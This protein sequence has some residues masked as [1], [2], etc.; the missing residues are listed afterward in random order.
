M[1]KEVFL[2][3]SDSSLMSDVTG[4]LRAAIKLPSRN[5]KL[6]VLVTILLLF[7]FSILVTFHAVLAGPL[8]QK[9]EDF[10]D[11]PST[12]QKDAWIL[13]CL[14]FVFSVIFCVISLFGM[15]ATINSSSATY[16][17]NFIRF[18]ELLLMIQ[19]TWKRLIITGL[20]FLLITIA[21]VFL[22]LMMLEAFILITSV[23]ATVAWI[24]IVGISATLLYL[25]PATV[26]MLGL[27]ISILEDCYGMKALGKARELIKGRKVQGFVLML[28]LEL[29]STPI[30]F[31]LILLTVDD[32]DDLGAM[33][34]IAFGSVFTFL[35]CIVRLF[36]FV[37]YT[38]FYY[39]C[40]KG[41]EENVP[42]E[43]WS[44][45]YNVNPISFD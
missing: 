32:D 22:C 2:A 13:V 10:N 8:L 27:V 37:V 6:T 34:Q 5:R 11:S 14:E 41:H 9:L 21:Y 24:S 25:Y 40:K 16:Q 43:L 30:S 17:G 3:S 36:A 28:F 29:L 31:L 26:F 45:G 12:A 38:L 44:T 7:P 23:G 35:F 39:E 4:V 18:R 33:T 1:D 42:I 20:Y 15:A 19:A